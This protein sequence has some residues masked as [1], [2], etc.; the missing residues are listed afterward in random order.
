MTP[1][2][3]LPAALAALAALVIPLAIHLARKSE[4]RPTDFAALRWLRQRPKP[5]HRIRFD[6]WPLLLARSLLVTLLALYLAAPALRGAGGAATWIAVIP[7]ATAPAPLPK[8]AEVRWLAPGFPPVTEP[9]PGP[10]TGIPVGSLLRQ[11]D[12]ELP[13]ATRLTVLAPAILSGADAERPRLSRPIEWRIVPGTMPAAAPRPAATPPPVL[14]IHAVSAQAGALR[15]IRAAATAWNPAAKRPVEA[16]A[17]ALP[18]IGVGLIWFDAGDLPAAVTDW[19]RRGGTVVVSAA[20]PARDAIPVWRDGAGVPIAEQATLGR[21][22][23]I[24]FTRSL[25]PAAMPD[26]LEPDFPTRLRTLLEPP[27]PPPTRV[28]AADYRPLAGG[29]PYAQPAQDLRPWLALSI[30]VL[31]LA[32][33]WLATRRRRGIAP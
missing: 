28:R 11:I 31:L 16:D 14:A 18:A 21:G 2:L 32:E 23:I 17:G 3:L 10:T 22:R 26:L 27:P 9:A 8:D 6:E 19:V 20:T 7:G 29:D 33:R 30:A 4:Q 24:R 25:T 15:Y 12:S 5:R 1:T 13:P